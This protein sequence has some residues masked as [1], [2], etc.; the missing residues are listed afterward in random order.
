[1]IYGLRPLLPGF[2]AC[3]LTA[4]QNLNQGPCA[5]LIKVTVFFAIRKKYVYS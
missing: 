2:R 1:M 5:A 3:P 4:A